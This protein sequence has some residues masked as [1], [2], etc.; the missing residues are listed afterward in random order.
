MFF[1]MSVTKNGLQGYKALSSEKQM[2]EQKQVISDTCHRKIIY[3]PQ[4]Q[5]R[6][7]ISWSV[8]LSVQHS[9]Q[10]NPATSTVL[11]LNVFLKC[12]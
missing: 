5:S 6:I 8:L 9:F 10:K 11:F 12:S 7:L 3:M 4:C 2:K 1:N